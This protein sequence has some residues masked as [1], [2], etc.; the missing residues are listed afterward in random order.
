MGSESRSR[1]LRAR[2]ETVARPQSTGRAVIVYL[3][4]LAA[5]LALVL[6]LLRFL[7]P[8]PPLVPR[9]GANALAPERVAFF[10]RNADKYDMVFLGDSR[11]Y[12]G[13]HPE[14]IDP[15]LGTRSTNLSIFSNWF[16]TQFPL[17]RDVLRAIRPG[18]VVVW[19]IGD[20]NFYAPNNIQP[21]YPI[22]FG[23][24]LRYKWWGVPDKDL[25]TSVLLSNPWTRPL[26]ERKQQHAKLIS[27]LDQPWISAPPAALA[28]DPIVPESTRARPADPFGAEADALARSWLRHP[29][30]NDVQVVRDESRATS[31]TVYF[32]GGGYYRIEV[33]GAFFRSKQKALDTTVATAR[34][35]AVPAAD[36]GMVRLF[37][38]ILREFKARGA[39]L[40][41]NEL[42]EAPHVY[43]HPIYRERRRVY[44]QALARPL[45]ESMGFAYIRAD[46]DQLEDADYFD[47]NH[48]NSRGVAKYSPLLADKLR[49][50]L[51]ARPR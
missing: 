32:R 2:W 37:V 13:I 33:D 30:V 49:P 4:M 11:T 36:P 17:A 24:A 43:R 9:E 20:Q 50:L 35:L 40:I 28:E 14:F 42:E 39:R 48:M 22:D 10:A 8:P 27:W 51:A 47:Y 46:L 7:N 31:V 44:L 15:L 5:C 19:S 38:E 1:G 12:C 29:D 41:V 3:I 18:A 25:W 23:T 21:V 16:P 45:V 34:S 26:G 6:A